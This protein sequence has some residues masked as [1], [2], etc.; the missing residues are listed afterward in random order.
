M[1]LSG[2][3]GLLDGFARAGNFSVFLADASM[4][5][6]C[7]RTG[8]SGF[9]LKAAN[10]PALSAYC[11]HS[12][13]LGASQAALL[14]GPFTQVCPLGLLETVIPVIPGGEPEAYLIVG[15][16]RCASYPKGL[17]RVPSPPGGTVDL[18]KDDPMAGAMLEAIPQIDY[19]FF[20]S[21]TALVQKTVLALFPEGKP[22]DGAAPG[23]APQ[24]GAVPQPGALPQQGAVP[25]QGAAAA[26]VPNF[27]FLLSMVNSIA[28]LSILESASRTNALAILLAEHIKRSMQ[29]FQREFAGVGE[30]LDSISRYLLMQKTRYG[31]L[32]N[33]SVAAPSGIRDF[34]VPAGSLLPF[35]ERALFFGLRGDGNLLDLKVGAYRDGTGLAFEISDNL[36]LAQG[37][38]LPGG[39][40]FKEESELTLIEARL[41]NSLERFVLAYGAKPPMEAL[42]KGE[43]GTRYLIRLPRVGGDIFSQRPKG[44]P[45]AAHA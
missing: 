22:G 4:A 18:L 2:L 34:P 37:Q 45:G 25:Q 33:Y 41:E 14:K 13:R 15:Q 29:D 36:S 26:R 7:A 42:G 5:P 31:D 8:L 3:I 39:P 38:G 24:P 23:A 11:G 10:S 21:F 9:C 44:S 6:I 30:E 27:H 43:G 35:V 12:H 1:E 20:E 17:L 28:N 16:A 32:L 40:P 19:S